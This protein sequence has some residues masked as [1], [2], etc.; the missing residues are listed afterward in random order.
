MTRLSQK[1]ALMR[2]S[3]RGMKIRRHT[4]LIGRGKAMADEVLSR[5]ERLVADPLFNRYAKFAKE[6]RAFFEL[7]GEDLASSN[8]EVQEIAFWALD[9]TTPEL[10]SILYE[11]EVR[12]PGWRSREGKDQQA[13]N[14]GMDIVTYLHRVFV[15]NHTFKTR[16][17][18][19][20]DPRP[21]VNRIAHNWQKDEYRK[22]GREAPLDDKDAFKLPDPAPSLEESV[23]GNNAYEMR[24]RELRALGF[25]RSEDEL[26]LYVA[27][28]VDRSRLD[29]VQKR[30]GI[31]SNTALRKRSSRTNKHMIFVRDEIFSILLL[32]YLRN[33]EKYREHLRTEQQQR[34]YEEW[35]KWLNIS[36]QDRRWLNGIAPDGTN[37]VAVQALTIDF[38]DVPAH[39]YLVAIHRDSIFKFVPTFEQ[40]KETPYWE[41]ADSYEMPPD[42]R[43]V[44]QVIRQ[45]SKTHPRLRDRV[46]TVSTQLCSYIRA[47]LS[48]LYDVLSAVPDDYESWIWTD[49]LTTIY[50]SI[51][52]DQGT[53]GHS[54]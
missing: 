41:F 5:W 1:K 54:E 10:T 7:I 8:Q 53:L 33:G 48:G 15:V 40:S 51:Q 29:E 27:T 12:E 9:Y 42:W 3:Y 44:S 6:P 39:I 50:R 21:L 49:S 11:R 22:R 32:N 2:V 35:T 17:G 46:I 19:G 16:N 25:F 36:V 28:H 52:I 43:S 31:R 23:I 37:E 47:E 24:T 45:S 14:R 13:V 26:D 18:Y 34:F 38:S 20:K 30:L 4:G